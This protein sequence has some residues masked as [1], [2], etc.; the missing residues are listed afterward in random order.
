MLIYNFVLIP[1]VQ[2]RDSA[3]YMYTFFSIFFSIVIYLKTVNI[4]PCALQ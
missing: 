1:A 3:L 4:I 2:Y